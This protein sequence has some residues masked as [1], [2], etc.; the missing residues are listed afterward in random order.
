MI[1]GRRRNLLSVY[2]GTNDGRTHRCER[3][4]LALGMGLGIGSS[5]VRIQ[6]ESLFPLFLLLSGRSRNSVAQLLL[7]AQTS[8]FTDELTDTHRA[9]R[10]SLSFSR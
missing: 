3:I 2:L 9:V 4:G 1:G 7:F 10:L 6:F 5:A 8:E